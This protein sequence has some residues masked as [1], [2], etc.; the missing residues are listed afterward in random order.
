[1]CS[2]GNHKQKE[3]TTYGL[4]E[5]I[6]KRC[7]QQGI[8]F[9]NTRTGHTALYQKTNNP[10]K[11]WSEDLNR[12][13]SKEDIQMAN[14]H[15]KSC[16]ISL[17]IREMQIKTMRYHLM[18]VRMAII[19]K[20]ANKKCWRGVEKKEPSCTIGGNVNWYSHHGEQYGGSLKN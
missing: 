11:T 2:K 12:Y 9:Q 10:I 20:F 14:R 4:G 8:N 5:N 15:K 1:M 6:C 17:I 3:K 19:K 16:S 18:P 13:F 7:Y